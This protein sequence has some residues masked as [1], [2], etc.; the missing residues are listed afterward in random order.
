MDFA[1][2]LT[3]LSHTQQQ[4]QVNTANIADSSRIDLNIHKGKS[5]MLKYKT[6]SINYITLDGESLEQVGVSIYL[7][8][9]IDKQ[10]GS[11]EDVKVRIEKARTTFLQL[12]DI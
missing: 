12:E 4:M 2:D 3:L 5:R 6:V 1:D 7:Q 8:I 10:R 9:F 11:D